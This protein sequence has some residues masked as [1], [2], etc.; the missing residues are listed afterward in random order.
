ML[1]YGPRINVESVLDD[2]LDDIQVNG[3][4]CPDSVPPN[5]TPEEMSEMLDEFLKDISLKNELQLLSEEEMNE[6]LA[7]LESMAKLLYENLHSS[8]A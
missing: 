2:L 3:D 5:C 1:I 6:L 4:M 7:E 8:N